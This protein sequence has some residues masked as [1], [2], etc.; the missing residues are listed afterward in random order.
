[1][2]PRDESAYTIYHRR[3]SKDRPYFMAVRCASGRV[4]VSI[5][6]KIY[7]PN[8]NGRRYLSTFTPGGLSYNPGIGLAM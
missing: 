6:L 5:V 2:R 7:P 1:M 3:R 4:L 8:Q